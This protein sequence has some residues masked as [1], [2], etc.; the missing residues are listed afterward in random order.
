[1]KDIDH[2]EK[3]SY[4]YRNNI[5]NF[6]M[7]LVDLINS[8]DNKK[9][10]IFFSGLGVSEKSSSRRSKFIAR[11]EDYIIKNLLNASIIRPSIVLHA[12]GCII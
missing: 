12:C 6:N 11:T 7:Q 3:K 8:I 9:P 5:L 1:M 10:L 4:S 2:R